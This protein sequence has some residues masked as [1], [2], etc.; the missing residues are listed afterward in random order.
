MIGMKCKIPISVMLKLT[1]KVDFLVMLN[2]R[3]LYNSLFVY[4][5]LL[6]NY[7]NNVNIFLISDFDQLVF[8]YKTFLP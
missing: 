5:S 1:F 2:P 8:A 7:P 6:T 3:T 4:V